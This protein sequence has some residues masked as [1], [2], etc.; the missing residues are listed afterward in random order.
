MNH[1]MYKYVM[2]ELR[3][4]RGKWKDVCDGSGVPYGTISKISSGALKNPAFQTVAKLEKYF[5]DLEAEK[6][7]SETLAD[8]NGAAEG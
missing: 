1:P 2:A 6:A 4:K 5:K 7:L 8:E 3:D